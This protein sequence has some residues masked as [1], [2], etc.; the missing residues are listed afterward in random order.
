MA[1]RIDRG[2]LSKP[3]K[4]S[5]GW[6]RI[7]GR[8]TRT[9]VFTYRNN[10]GTMRRELRLPEEVF[11]SDAMQS[12]ALVPVTDEHPPGFLDAKNTREYARGSVAGTLRKDGEFVAG[13]LLVTDADLIKKLEDGAA[14]EL[15]C[16]YNCDLD[17][18]PGITSDGLRYDAI[19]RNIRGNHVAVVAKGRAGPEA[20]VRMDGASVEVL[21]GDDDQPRDEN[22]QWSSTGGGGS[23]KPSATL[24]TPTLKSGK[25]FG[26]KML[27][28]REGRAAA[29]EKDIKDLESVI[30]EARR[31]GA[32]TVFD[33]RT[34]NSL[35][36]YEAA[37][38]L[39][40]KQA[41]LEREKE[42]IRKEKLNRLP[43]PKAPEASPADRAAQMKARVANAVRGEPTKGQEAVAAKHLGFKTLKS[44]GSD[45]KDFSEASREGLERAVRAMNPGLGEDQVKGIAS[46]YFVPKGSGG[47]AADFTEIS[48][49]GVQDMLK[50]AGYTRGNRDPMNRPDINPYANPDQPPL[51]RT[52]LWSSNSK[53]RALEFKPKPK[54]AEK[55]KRSVPLRL[56]QGRALMNPKMPWSDS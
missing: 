44:E 20:R 29:L 16:G 43:F 17:E 37:E 42:S 14:R 47:S 2:N 11:K 13:E 40:E 7:D 28:K 10:D 45:S 49:W 4:M 27:A 39:Q 30:D 36:V 1:Y 8:L 56:Q 6:L 35:K 25:S 24:K 34:A 3:V 21:D 50:E 12:F 26:E 18:K 53:V 15:S 19:Q 23:S 41:D 33:P 5:N 31:E 46:K 32:D 38:K 52:S 22:G 48:K 9:G 51:Q 55:P 54:P